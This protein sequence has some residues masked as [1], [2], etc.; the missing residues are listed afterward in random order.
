M[1]RL[2][3]IARRRL[4]LLRRH[5]VCPIRRYTSTNLASRYA[6]VAQYRGGPINVG[7]GTPLADHVFV[8]RLWGAVRGFLLPHIL[9]PFDELATFPSGVRLVGTR[10]G[11]ALRKDSQGE[12]IIR[13]FPWRNG[14]LLRTLRF[15]H[16][17]ERVRGRSPLRVNLRRVLFLPVLRRAI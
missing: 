8:S 5:L 11:R 16:D 9:L 15:F 7:H 6:R 14:R 2:V 3:H 17:W 1:G 4:N 10:E 13:R 12:P